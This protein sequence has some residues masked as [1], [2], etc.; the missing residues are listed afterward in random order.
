L[1]F[2]L[3]FIWMGYLMVN[4]FQGVFLPNY[5][6]ML[7]VTCIKIYVEKIMARGLSAKIAGT[8]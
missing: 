8:C 5:F 7:H 4:G 3:I 1:Y 2:N 6:N